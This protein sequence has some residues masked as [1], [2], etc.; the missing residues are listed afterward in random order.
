MRTIKIET[1]IKNTMENFISING[2]KD[3]D[4]TIEGNTFF[5]VAPNRFSQ[6]YIKYISNGSVW[7]ADLKKSDPTKVSCVKQAQVWG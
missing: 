4:T 3:A 1:T 2:V 5:L 6:G 7:V